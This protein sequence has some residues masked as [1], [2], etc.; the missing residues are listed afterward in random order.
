MLRFMLF[1]LALL[2]GIMKKE[3]IEINTQIKINDRDK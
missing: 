3:K 1:A 2:S